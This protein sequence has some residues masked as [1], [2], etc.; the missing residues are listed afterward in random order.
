MRLVHGTGGSP[1]RLR[2]GCV[3]AGVE[4]ASAPSKEMRGVLISRRQQAE[5]P[6]I[7]NKTIGIIRTA[8]KRRSAGG[9]GGLLAPPADC[10]R[11]L[12]RRRVA[13]PPARAR[14]VHARTGR[15]GG[16][17]EPDLWSSPG[18]LAGPANEL[19]H[20]TGRRFQAT[21]PRLAS[22]FTFLEPGDDV[23]P[24]AGPPRLARAVRP[25]QGAGGRDAA[26]HLR[27]GG[28]G[29][30]AGRGLPHSPRR[31]SCSGRAWATA[32][33]RLPTS[34]TGSDA[35]GA[36][37]HWQGAPEGRSATPQAGVTRPSGSG[38]TAAPEG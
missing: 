12:A 36:P 9:G 4:T 19:E 30:A 27:D 37:R 23:A 17:V 25:G 6:A 7:P 33:S 35:T 29:A 18:R 13:R 2:A 10:R 31:A 3:L 1:A 34:S 16:G 24:G 11:R 26:A 21:V 20:G 5:Y 22:R 38:W 32:G 8:G 14:G 15:R 28:R